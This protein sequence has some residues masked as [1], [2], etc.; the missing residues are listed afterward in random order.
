M[1]RLI[2]II[3][4]CTGVLWGGPAG[5]DGADDA[6]WDN[7][8]A[9]FKRGDS[10]KGAA[11]LRNLAEKGDA[12]AQN[13]LGVMYDY[14]EGVPKDH[15]EAMK[16]YRRAAEQGYAR[17]Q[18]R[19][20]LMYYNGQGAPQ[21]YAKALKWYRKSAEQGLNLSQVKLGVMY[22]EGKGVPQNYVQAHMWLNLAAQG[23]EDAKLLRDALAKLMT[24][25]Q[26]AEAQKL[27][28]EWRP[29]K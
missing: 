15:A 2:L 18:D 24:S 25:A 27:A 26:I 3:A 22:E 8:I 16:W 17:A 12:K 28:R 14:G 9:A 10:A 7:V 5:A 6:V 29:K 20:G 1:R 21:N 4:I 19:L 23:I 11:N 13:N